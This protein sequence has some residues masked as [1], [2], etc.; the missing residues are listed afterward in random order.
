MATESEFVGQA[1]ALARARSQCA[2]TADDV[3]AQARYKLSLDPT[4]EEVKKVCTSMRKF[5][6]DERVVFHYNVSLR[7]VGLRS[8][9]HL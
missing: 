3:G 8:L 2:L 6:K 1:H 9:A 7:C 5:A 4:V